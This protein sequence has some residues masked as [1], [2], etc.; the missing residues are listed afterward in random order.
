MANFV[1]YA[2][3]QSLITAI[4]QK[5]NAVE[6]A[7]VFKGSATL[8]T[9]PDTLTATMVGYVYNM[10]EEFTTTADFVEGAGKKYP[11]GTN[12]AICDIGTAQAPSYK[13]DVLAGFIDVDAIYNAIADVSAMIADEFLATENYDEGDLVTKE[14]VL[15][16]FT[17]DHTAGAWDSEEVEEVTVEGLIA[18][19][20]AAADGLKA[21][22]DATQADIAPIFDATSGTYAVGDLV[23]YNNQLYKFNTAHDVA[24]AWVA[25]EA[26]AIDIDTIV[27]ALKLADTNLGLRVDQVRADLAPAFDATQAYA[28]GDVVTYT[29]DKLYKFTAAHAAGAWTGEDV[30]ETTV[31]GLIDVAEPDPLTTEQ[32][33]AL[34]TLLD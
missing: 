28:V 17:D 13:F 31:A 18:D 14:G 4:A 21:R 16:R 32:V 10:S 6:G 34:I 7:Y 33:N 27:K 1:S 30:T 22:V 24:G 9:L 5:F 20:V 15:Y 26:D 8:A 11:A 19:I 3:A 12:V 23:I 2:N 29:D 25:A